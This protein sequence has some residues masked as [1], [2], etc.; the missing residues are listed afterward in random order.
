MIIMPRFFF[1][2]ERNI[3]MRA[4]SCHKRRSAIWIIMPHFFS[5][6]NHLTRVRRC[7]MRS[8]RCANMIIMP[9]FSYREEPLDEGEEMSQEEWEGWVARR[10]EEA[11]LHVAWSGR[12]FFQDEDDD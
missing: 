6:R 5:E 12:F 3:L 10:R 8:G 4:R 11:G 7:P 2:S 9:R 1:L